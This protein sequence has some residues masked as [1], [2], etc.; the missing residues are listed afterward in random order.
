M[1]N[2]IKKNSKELST[3]LLPIWPPAIWFVIDFD[4]IRRA[5]ANAAERLIPGMLS[6][7]SV[8]LRREAVARLV[9]QAGDLVKKNN[10]PAAILIYRQALDAAR[11]A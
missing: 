4:L 11:N 3:A 1:K 2:W 6:D 9:G 5:D 7:P 10:K 8:D